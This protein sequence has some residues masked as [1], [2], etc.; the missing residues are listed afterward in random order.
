MKN[1]TVCT[2]AQPFGAFWPE[3]S[4]G[5]LR[6]PGLRLG[7]GTLSANRAPSL[8]AVIYLGVDAARDICFFS[9]FCGVCGFT[10]ADVILHPGAATV[11]TGSH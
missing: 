2:I 8:I 3:R 6:N 9:V 7:F 1:C 10:G 11:A 4:A 5:D